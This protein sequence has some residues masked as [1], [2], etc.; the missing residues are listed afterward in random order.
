MNT[1]QTMLTIAALAMLSVLT[2]NYYG[3]MAR[4]GNNISQTQAGISATTLATSYIELAQNTNFDKVTYESDTALRNP[5]LLTPPELLGREDVT[6]D[7][8]QNFNDFDDFD[9]WTENKSLGVMGDIFTAK[10]E[11]YY[12]NPNN[13]DQ[14]VSYRT[15]VKRM[16]IKV[17]RSYPP[18]DTADAVSFDTARVTCILGYFKFS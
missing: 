17:W 6:D 12:V 7:S 13:I 16:N 2:L 8:I 4:N 18:I 1:G 10:F 3:S 14:K 15:F 11:V 5:N 9:G